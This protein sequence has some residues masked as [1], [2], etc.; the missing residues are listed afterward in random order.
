MFQ[1]FYGKIRTRLKK[2]DLKAA[3]DLVFELIVGNLQIQQHSCLHFFHF[4]QK[5]AY[6]EKIILLILYSV[7]CESNKITF[8]VQNNFFP[9]ILPIASI[10]VPRHLFNLLDVP[11][12]F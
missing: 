9:G 2:Q 8:L 7:N 5:V 11:K 3:K 10:A 1:T 12:K 6:I 4:K